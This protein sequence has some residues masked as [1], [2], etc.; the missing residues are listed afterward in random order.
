ML[1]ERIR[2][3]PLDELW[4]GLEVEEARTLVADLAGLLRRIHGWRPA[5]DAAA[6]LLDGVPDPGM[7]P[8][9]IA[10]RTPVALPV[11]LARRLAAA[12]RSMPF[13]DAALLDRVERRLDELS[14]A[15][16]MAG[17]EEDRWSSMA[18]PRSGT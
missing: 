5:G 16:P 17:P 18:T 2:G 12:A 11:P 14:G 10:G 4:P 3:R 8:D 15:D 7:E 9:G 6:L 1:V 13:V